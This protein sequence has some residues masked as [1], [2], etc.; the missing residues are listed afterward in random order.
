M[1]DRDRLQ[2]FFIAAYGRPADTAGLE[3]W[4]GILDNELKGNEQ[5]LLTNF[6]NNQQTEYVDLY[7]ENPTIAD[8]I[9]SVF[10]NLF[11]RVPSVE[12]IDYWQS[13]F[14]NK[15]ALVGANADDVRGQLM[16][17]IMDGALDV[18]PIFDATTVANKLQ[19]AKLFTAAIDTADEVAAYS[20]ADNEVGLDVG[21]DFLAGITNDKATVAAAEAALNVEVAKVVTAAI[22]EIP[23]KDV[24]MAVADEINLE[25]AAVNIDLA[26]VGATDMTALTVSGLGSNNADIINAVSTVTDA[27]AATDAV[28]MNSS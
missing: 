15:M 24:T 9:T 6:A 21:R 27:S 14:E 11:N 8:F 7:G 16:I 13:V 3:Y 18:D 23:L 17:F 12:A 2:K 4:E 19:A 22:A 26:G 10:D 28:V 1:A 20:N 5:L 25:T